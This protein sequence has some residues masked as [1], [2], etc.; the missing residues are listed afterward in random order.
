MPIMDGLEALKELRRK[1][2]TVA[3]IMCTAM[4][5]QAMVVD[6]ITHGASDFIVKPFEESRVIEAITKVLGK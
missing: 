6:A 4:G 3:V 5:Q 1:G 2:N